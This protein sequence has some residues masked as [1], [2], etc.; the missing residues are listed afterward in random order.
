MSVLAAAAAVERAE[1]VSEATT[2]AVKT[3]KRSSSLIK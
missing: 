1:A 2:A 3:T